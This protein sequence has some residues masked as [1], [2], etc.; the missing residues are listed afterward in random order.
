[1]PHLRTHKGFSDIEQD[2]TLFYDDG[3]VDALTTALKVAARA[4]I[5]AQ[6]LFSEPSDDINM[7]KQKVF[8]QKVFYLIMQRQDELGRQ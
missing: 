1:M 5:I 3:T 6:P 4:L 7:L 2:I 8:E